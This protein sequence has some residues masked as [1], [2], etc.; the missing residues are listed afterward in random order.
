MSSDH[1]LE[2]LP[3]VSDGLFPLCTGQWKLETIFIFPKS[4]NWRELC[5]SHFGLWVEMFAHLDGL[6]HVTA[7]ELS[8]CCCKTCLWQAW[9]AW[10]KKLNVLWQ[11]LVKQIHCSRLRATTSRHPAEED[12]GGNSTTHSCKACPCWYSGNLIFAAFSSWLFCWGYHW[13]LFILSVPHL[14]PRSH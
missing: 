10:S 12:T 11:D 7:A 2:V 9:T 5:R 6:L 13:C 8:Y 3:L 4:V 1:P 14:P